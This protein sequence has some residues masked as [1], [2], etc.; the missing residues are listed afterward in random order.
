MQI[1]IIANAVLFFITS[2]SYPFPSKYRRFA[3]S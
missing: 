1:R 3:S 2:K